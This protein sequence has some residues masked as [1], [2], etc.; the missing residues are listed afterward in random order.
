MAVTRF[1]VVEEFCTEI[2]N[3]APQIDRGIVR[4][5]GMSRLSSVSP[6]IRH[7]FAV[8]SYSVHGQIVILE[9]YC[10][11]VWGV[12]KELDQKVYAQEDE[13]RRAVARTCDALGLQ[14]RAG[15][16]ER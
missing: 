16:L 9:C 6:N 12:N 2:E 11:D 13:V 10:G 5:T 15:I 3:D 14:Q 4:I 1:N 8:A 7:I